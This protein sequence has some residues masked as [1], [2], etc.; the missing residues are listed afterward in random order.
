MSEPLLQII[1]GLKLLWISVF[2]MLYGFGGISGKWKRRFLGPLWMT[3]GLYIFDI[4]GW[5]WEYLFFTLIMT[6]G[7]TVGYGKKSSLLNFFRG[8]EFFTRLF[9]GLLLGFAPIFIAIYNS[10][11]V[12]WYIHIALCSGFASVF[13]T[14][15]L[16]KSAREEE[17]LIAVGVSLLPLFMLS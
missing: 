1:A 15:N 2:A 3:A 9:I 16:A 17:T 13:G 5:H 14:F 11:F 7:L 12:L 4:S 8:N 6:I 10:S